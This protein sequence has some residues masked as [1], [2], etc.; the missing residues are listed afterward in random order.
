ML[1]HWNPLAMDKYAYNYNYYYYVKQT[2]DS[3][4]SI[5]TWASQSYLHTLQWWLHL[6]TRYP[7]GSSSIE[8]VNCASLM[9]IY[10]LYFRL[11]TCLDFLALLSNP[12]EDQDTNYAIIHAIYQDIYGYKNHWVTPAN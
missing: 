9:P 3:Q 10:P 1:H 5:Q 11:Q 7:F 4:L 2:F 6:F 12:P 8:R